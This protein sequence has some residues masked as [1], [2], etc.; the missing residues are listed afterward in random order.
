[1]N[2][3]GNLKFSS[4]RLKEYKKKQMKY[5]FVFYLTP[6]TV[7]STRSQY[8]NYED[9]ALFFHRVPETQYSIHPQHTSILTDHG[10]ALKNYRDPGLMHRTAQV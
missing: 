3:I 4:N 10:A 8:K 5:T 9:T 7:I 6:N 2:H 1:M